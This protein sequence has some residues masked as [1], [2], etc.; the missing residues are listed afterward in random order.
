MIFTPPVVSGIACAILIIM[1]MALMLTVVLSRRQN[2]QSL[3]DGDNSGLQR[4][5][6]RHGNLAENAAIFCVGS[7]LLEMLG[8]S[9]TTVEVLSAIFILGRISHAIGL[10]MPAT[11]N[12]FRIF[13]VGATTLVGIALG[14]R[15]VVASL[16]LF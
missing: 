16:A 6:R 5:I 7:A 11:V 15:L 12:R 2:K 4:A 14:V 1:Q 13:G 9:R 3:G 10:S 8:G